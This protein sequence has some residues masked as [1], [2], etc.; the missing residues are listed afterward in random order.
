MPQVLLAHS[1]NIRSL[2][3][4]GRYGYKQACFFFLES[5]ESSKMLDIENGSGECK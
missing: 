3:T 1:F 5:K 4:H 2:Q